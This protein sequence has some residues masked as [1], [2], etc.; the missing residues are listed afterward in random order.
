M[1]ANKKRS[2]FCAYCGY[3]GE[4]TVDHIPPKGMFGKPLPANLITVPACKKCHEKTRDDD[5][6]FRTA[7]ALRHDVYDH[8]DVQDVLPRVLRSFSNKIKVRFARAFFAKRCSIEVKTKAG[9]YLG[10]REGFQVD[11]P[12]LNRVT[13]RMTLGLYLL[14]TGNRIPDDWCAA[15]MSDDDFNSQPSDAQAEFAKSIRIVLRNP[16]KTIGKNVFSYQF[17]LAS[18]NPLSSLWVFTFYDKSSFMT[19]TAPKSAGPTLAD[20]R[21][22]WPPRNRF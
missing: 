21:E 8:P 20:R 16:K 7:L 17:A 6:Y 9:I 10:N 3:D 4:L 18:D 22:P 14:E 15:S 11:L 5:E 1:V 12:R 13:N 19:L 2:K